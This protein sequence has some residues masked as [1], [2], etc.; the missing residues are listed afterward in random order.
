M[1]IP[2]YEVEF[3]PLERRLIDRRL[4]P[5]SVAIER[6]RVSERRNDALARH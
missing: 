4:A 1:T 2:Q 5:R 3:I 6:R